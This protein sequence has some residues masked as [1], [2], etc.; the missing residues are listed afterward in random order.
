MDFGNF[1][2]IGT[3]EYTKDVSTTNS[4][5]E[6]SP[7]VYD[8]YLQIESDR[9]FDSAALFTKMVADGASAS[10]TNSVIE[11]LNKYFESLGMTVAEVRASSIQPLTNEF[12]A[13]PVVYWTEGKDTDVMAIFKVK[14]EYPC[15]Y[16]MRYGHQRQ[17]TAAGL[18]W[19]RSSITWS[20]V[21]MDHLQELWQA[22]LHL[23][24]SQDPQL[25]SLRA[26]KSC[27]YSKQEFLQSIFTA[28]TQINTNCQLPR[29]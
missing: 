14:N 15:S 20:L 22:A 1:L 3:P 29:Y 5:Y 8:L 12:D 16:L 26:N 21:N 28:D 27:H 25:L 18:R 9:G 6:G 11:Q 23:L 13:Y 2:S 4:T 19:K 7:A 17:H 24:D 10:A